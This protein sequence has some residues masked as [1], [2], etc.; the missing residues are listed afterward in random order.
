MNKPANI[1]LLILAGVVAVG[2]QRFFLSTPKVV[3]AESANLKS[4]S[5]EG[6]V[7]SVDA[8]ATDQSAHSALRYARV[9]LSTGETIRAF[10]G[11]CV[12]FP[13]QIT[14]LAKYGSGSNASY[15][16]IENGRDGS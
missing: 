10:V 15:G 6:R 1:A 8:P 2:A 12:I 7:L 11:G 4:D 16:V 14:R 5:F 9:K 3:V 13:G